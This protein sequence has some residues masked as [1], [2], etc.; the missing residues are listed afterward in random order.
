[1]Q[2]FTQKPKLA[3]THADVI[4]YIKLGILSTITLIMIGLTYFLYGEFYQT[5]VQARAV[6]VLKQEVALE[7]VELEAFNRARALH[8]YKKSQTLPA[9]V[10]DPFRTAGTTPAPESAPP[11]TPETT[12]PSAPE[13]EAQGIQEQ[14][15]SLFQ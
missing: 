1:M 9:V 15:P 8:E 4:A 7:D 3:R 6:L 13:S 2:R 12:S 5:I 10:P 14:F 11:P